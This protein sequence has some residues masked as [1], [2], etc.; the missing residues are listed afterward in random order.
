M[1]RRCPHLAP[2]ASPLRPPA[3]AGRRQ[4]RFYY[5]G[6]SLHLISDEIFK[7]Q[8]KIDVRNAVNR[9]YVDNR[10]L[11]DRDVEKRLAPGLRPWRTSGHVANEKFRSGVATDRFANNNLNLMPIDLLSIL[12]RRNDRRERRYIKHRISAAD[13]KRRKRDHAAQQRGEMVALHLGDMIG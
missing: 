6:C 4:T 12:F 10:R 2:Q 13:I 11:E 9:S 7:G 5:S 3:G 1:A 8:I